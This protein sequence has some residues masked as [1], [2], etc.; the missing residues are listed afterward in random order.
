MYFVE[1]TKNERFRA[2]HEIGHA[3][4]AEELG[5][6]WSVISIGM[7]ERTAGYIRYDEIEETEDNIEK[8]LLFKT[9]GE[10]ITHMIYDELSAISS[11]QCDRKNIH[12]FLKKVDTKYK[13][14][15]VNDYIYRAVLNN[16]ETFKRLDIKT[17]IK[18]IILALIDRKALSR[19]EFLTILAAQNQ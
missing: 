2:T 16:I 18:P 12:D 10:A 11:A 9:A 8:Y 17:F 13:E 15:A 14:N 3:I 7:G 1:L 5:V 4:I 19:D 6:K